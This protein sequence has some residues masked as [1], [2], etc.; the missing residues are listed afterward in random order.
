MVGPCVQM[1]LPTHWVQNSALLLSVVGH[2][3][4]PLFFKG[5]VL[6][7]LTGLL[8]VHRK[9]ASAGKGCPRALANTVCSWASF[10]PEL[11]PVQD[12]S[13]LDLKPYST[14]QQVYLR[15]LTLSG[16]EAQ[17][18]PGAAFR[19]CSVTYG[20]PIHAHAWQFRG[21][22]KN[23]GAPA[24]PLRCSTLP[25]HGRGGSDQEHAGMCPG[26]QG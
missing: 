9:T 21:W 4:D 5:G 18:S 17:R 20:A 3:R 13:L 22:G 11:M 26:I 1:E 25:A 6:C 12:V 14:T 8:L 16:P 15:A 19:G 24:Q 23:R 2:R 10:G 7:F